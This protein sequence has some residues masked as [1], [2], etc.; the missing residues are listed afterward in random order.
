[1][2]MVAYPSPIICL[3][4]P[5]PRCCHCAETFRVP[6]IYF[7]TLWRDV[8]HH[9]VLDYPTQQRMLVPLLALAYA[10]HFSGQHMQSAYYHYLDTQ[11]ASA[12]PDLH[13]TSAGLKALVTQVKKIIYIKAMRGI[14]GRPPMP[15][16]ALFSYRE[17]K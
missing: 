9:Q 11:D 1:M 7:T 10:L 5:S 8:C 6:I 12:L 2:D 17:R 16:M 3:P 15:R 13:A 14:R 4:C